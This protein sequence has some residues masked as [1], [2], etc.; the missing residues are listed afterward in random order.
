MTKAFPLAKVVFAQTS[1]A[2]R[3]GFQMPYDNR[4]TA[5]SPALISKPALVQFDE[6]NTTSDGGALLLKAVEQKLGLIR[7]LS[8]TLL[9]HREFGK[10]R[11]TLADLIRQR[12]LGFACGY[13]DTD[14]PTHGTQQL[15]LFN[16]HYNHWCYLP[17]L[18]IAT[19]NDESDQHLLAAALRSGT[20]QPKRGTPAE[21]SDLG[22]PDLPSAWRQRESDQGADGQP[23]S[24]LDELSP[25][26][27]RPAAAA[28]DCSGCC[29]ATGTAPASGGHEIGHG[30]GGGLGSVTFQYRRPLPTPEVSTLENRL[31]YPDDRLL[32][33]EMGCRD[34]DHVISHPC[35]WEKEEIWTREYGS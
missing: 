22:L 34:Q 15:S 3:N 31:P 24:R 23:G 2:E 29:V 25:A 28:V 20:A 11:H 19:F 33:P 16:G 10:I 27:G 12:I 9:D 1:V 14:D 6:P 8:D 17:L 35:Q 7:R 18:A 30:S 26:W 13:R 32:P 21:R 4:Q 5:L